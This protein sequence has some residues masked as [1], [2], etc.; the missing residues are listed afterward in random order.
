MKKILY[1]SAILLFVFA[2]FG[3]AQA[4][5]GESGRDEWRVRTSTS[6][7][8]E[9]NQWSRGGEDD[10]G[11]KDGEEHP[12]FVRSPIRP[13]GGAP[14]RIDDDRDENDEDDEDDDSDD[15]S[16]T[17][18]VTGD[19]MDD[20]GDDSR[21]QGENRFKLFPFFKGQKH[22]GA[23]DIIARQE[24]ASGTGTHSPFF[25]E[26]KGESDHRNPRA[27]FRNKIGMRF[28]FAMHNLSNIRT[29]LGA[30]VDSLTTKGVD[31][32]TA[33]SLLATADADI[34]SATTAVDALQAKIDAVIVVTPPVDP[35]T[36]TVT[37]DTTV[38]QP[39]DEATKA[40]IRALATS[41]KDAIVKAYKS[42]GAVIMEIK[43]LHQENSISDEDDTA[44]SSTSSTAT[45][46]N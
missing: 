27:D 22:E 8:F 29:R 39:L 20:D 37:E 24:T 26:N 43:K 33:K 18:T 25:K 12:S 44:S 3:K 6:E 17:A 46:T 32:A 19:D 4:K 36:A 28:T 23:L 14:V 35:S 1:I 9:D 13:L 40:E 38:Q 15:T 5:D 30:H 16:M 34:A 2:V 7:S 41:A 45:T 31:T 11:D 10:E 42:L 21:K